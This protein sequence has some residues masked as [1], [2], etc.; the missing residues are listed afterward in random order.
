MAL[1][2]RSKL[3][4]VA[5]AF[6][7]VAG[8]CTWAIPLFAGKAFGIDSAWIEPSN[9]WLVA[10]ALGVASSIV[11][12]AFVEREGKLARIARRIIIT[13]GILLAIVATLTLVYVG[14]VVFAMRLSH[15]HSVR[16]G[17]SDLSASFDVAGGRADD[18]YGLA[19]RARGRSCAR[20]AF[21]TPPLETP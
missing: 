20:V 7:A 2:S 8:V 10:L 13:L 4:I 21:L 16:E 9:Y 1:S 17:A 5:S 14:L 3:G 15:N 19:A 18:G 11:A 12:A 6:F